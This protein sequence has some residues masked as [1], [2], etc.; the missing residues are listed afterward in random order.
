MKSSEIKNIIRQLIND[1]EQLD[2]NV[3]WN[4]TENVSKVA[5]NLISQA[6]ND[7]L[8]ISNK[9]QKNEQT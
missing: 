9:G 3:I 8:N 7:I 2:W 5:E 4:G 1:Y 6:V